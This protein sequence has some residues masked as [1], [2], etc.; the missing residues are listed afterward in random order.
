MLNLDT[1]ILID[2]MVG[3]LSQKEE[4]CVLKNEWCIS[5]IVLWELYKLNQVG[6]IEMD[7]NNPEIRSFLSSL[8]VYPIDLSILQAM[9]DL[10]FKSD[11]ADE[12]IAATS[13]AH[14]IPLLTRDNKIL[15]SKVTPFAKLR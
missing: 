14:K 4:K 6:R 2:I 12:I 9:D 8:T 5:D 10:D 11:P 13:I 7:F 3:H 15:S 1:H